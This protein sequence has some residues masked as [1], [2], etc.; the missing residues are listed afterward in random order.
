MLAKEHE[1]YD[2]S[3]FNTSVNGYKGDASLS[4]NSST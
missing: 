1:R 3:Y 4:P 2:G